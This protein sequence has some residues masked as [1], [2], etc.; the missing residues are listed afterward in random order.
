MEN[1]EK[2]YAAYE[3]L[4]ARHIIRTEI[5]KEMINS[6]IDVEK[7]LEYEMV[8]KISKR[9]VQTVEKRYTIQDITDTN[10]EFFNGNKV[11]EAEMYIFTREQ[12][13]NLLKIDIYKEYEYLR[14]IISERFKEILSKNILKLGT[15]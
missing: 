7:L 11:F 12:L 14:D 1:E 8:K 2:S 3:M 5:S 6:A 15:E 13:V 10:S 4:K 9:L